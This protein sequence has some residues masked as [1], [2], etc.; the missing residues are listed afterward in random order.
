MFQKQ[1][2]TTWLQLGLDNRNANNKIQ[3]TRS[4][5]STANRT[6]K[7]WKCNGNFSHV[8]HID[9]SR[10]TRIVASR[11]FSNSVRSVTTASDAAAAAVS[12]VIGHTRMRVN[13]R[14]RRRQPHP[15]CTASS[16]GHEG[17]SRPVEPHRRRSTDNLHTASVSHI[18]IPSVCTRSGS[19]AICRHRLQLPNRSS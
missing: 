14:R 1:S 17:A 2:E 11:I 3:C 19:P 13:C 8:Y 4:T 12:D 7:L 10:Q 15:P 5:N 16:I 18:A 9:N 6:I